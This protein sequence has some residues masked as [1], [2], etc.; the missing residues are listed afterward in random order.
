MDDEVVNRQMLKQKADTLSEI[1]AA[2]VL[3]YIGIMESVREEPN[4][5]LEETIAKLLCEAM[6]APVGFRLNQFRRHSTRN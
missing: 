1:E 6:V 2:E 3:E 5:P 4:D